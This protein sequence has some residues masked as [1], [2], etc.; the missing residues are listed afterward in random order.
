MPSLNVHFLPALTT[1][2]ALTGSA[3]VVIDVLRATTTIATALAAGARK[4]IPCQEVE[5]AREVAAKLPA[6]SVLLGGERAGTPIA[7]FDLGNSPLEYTPAR[8]AGKTL[9]FTTTNGTRALRHARLAKAIFCGAFVNLSAI[10]DHLRGE[11]RIDLLCAGTDGQVTAE[12][13]LFAGML[14]NRIASLDQRRGRKRDFGDAAAI[15]MAFH[16]SVGSSERSRFRVLC[17]SLGGRNLIELGMTP[18]IRY[19]AQLNRH[20]LAP[21][22]L[23]PSGHIVASRS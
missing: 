6:G 17:E 15:A 19:A 7:G 3:V 10:A 21:E 16:E 22:L 4:V 12:D 23:T 13:V 2:E 8:V 11:P 18:D 9:V 1:P 20:R 14:A 5:E